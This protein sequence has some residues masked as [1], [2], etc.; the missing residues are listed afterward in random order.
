MSGDLTAGCSSSEDGDM[1]VPQKDRDA[2]RGEQLM[3]RY[4]DGMGDVMDLGCKF[5]RVD[6][7][8]WER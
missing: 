4:G 6:V 3:S 5:S 8:E 1:R 2:M 7:E